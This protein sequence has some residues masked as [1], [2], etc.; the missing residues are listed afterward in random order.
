[1]VLTIFIFCSLMCCH[2][3]LCYSCVRARM[4][5]LRM[6]LTL[7]VLEARRLRAAALTATSSGGSWTLGTSAFSVQPSPVTTNGL[8][9]LSLRNFSS[10]RIPTWYIC[11]FV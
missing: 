4:H 8:S 1:M 11:V 6:G 9:L 2:R 5:T 7:S 10:V 3:L